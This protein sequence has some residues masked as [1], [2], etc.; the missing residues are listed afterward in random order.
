MIGKPHIED[1]PEQPYM[2]IRI[3]IPMKGMDK[4]IQRLHKEVS[5]WMKKRRV[6]PAGLPFVRYLVIDTK[7]EV[8]IEV[9]F[10]V[11]KLLAGDNRISVGVLPAGRYAS[12]I[13]SGSAGNRA[14]IEWA[15]ANSIAWDRW[16]D[17]RGEAFRSR[18]ETYLTDPEME[19]RKT[20]WDIELA[21]KLAD[22]QRSVEGVDDE[23]PVPCLF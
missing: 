6:E 13:Y 1:R 23:I 10:P 14:L 11:E 5:A 18:Y 2:G 9:G 19:S 17:S 21:I 16:N 22:E 3:Q 12:L 7:A 4:V 8:D 15:K 20:K